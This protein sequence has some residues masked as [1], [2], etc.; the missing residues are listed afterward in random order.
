M[1]KL[2]AQKKLQDLVLSR[3]KE[4]NKLAGNSY[5]KVNSLPNGGQ[6]NEA[7]ETLK[8]LG[9]EMFFLHSLHEE[10]R[11]ALRS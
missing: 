6:K 4:V 7:M 10:L 9:E 1:T 3:L 2:K 5:E 11:L 8:I